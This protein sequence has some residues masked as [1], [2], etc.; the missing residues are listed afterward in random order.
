[1]YAWKCP[2]SARVFVCVCVQ[3]S[4]R[5]TLISQVIFKLDLWCNTLTNHPNYH[6][7]S[8]IANADQHL[9]SS[10]ATTMTLVRLIFHFIH[11]RSFNY[12]NCTGL[13]LI[14]IVILL[15]SFACYKYSIMN[16]GND[17]RKTDDMK[18]YVLSDED[19]GRYVCI[20]QY[21]SQSCNRSSVQLLCLAAVV[22]TTLSGSR[23]SE[24]KNWYIHCAN[25]TRP[26]N[27]Y[28]NE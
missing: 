26:K 27:I 7:F 9:F 2:I 23:G 3:I 19:R 6:F 28:R 24:K 11:L 21:H 16:E 25:G 12:W 17:D 15:F 20:A 13:W 1:M 4:L 8:C 10:L 22:L 14:A 5:K 18:I